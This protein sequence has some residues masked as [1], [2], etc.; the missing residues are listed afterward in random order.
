[1]LS[2][3]S[4]FAEGDEEVLLSG[5]TTASSRDSLF[6]WLSLF[7]GKASTGRNSAE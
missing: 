2:N 4:V 5:L 3:S 1:M 7:L 6:S